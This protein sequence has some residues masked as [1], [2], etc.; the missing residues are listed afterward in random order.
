MTWR[1]GDRFALL[2]YVNEHGLLA[3]V[4]DGAKRQ[5]QSCAEQWE[6]LAHAVRAHRK[7]ARCAR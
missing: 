7:A 1:R 5:G 3:L 6:A 4:R 2:D